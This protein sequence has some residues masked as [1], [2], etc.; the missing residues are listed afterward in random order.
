MCNLINRLSCSEW[1]INFI[2][3]LSG[4]LYPFINGQYRQTPYEVDSSHLMYGCC[5]VVCAHVCMFVCCFVV[6]WYTVYF[7][8]IHIYIYFI[9]SYVCVFMCIVCVFIHIH[10]HTFMI[11]ICVC[12]CYTIMCTCT[13]YPS[14]RP[15]T[16]VTVDKLQ[17]D[18]AGVHVSSIAFCA[19][20]QQHIVVYASPWLLTCF[21]S[22]NKPHFVYQLCQTT[23][24][25]VVQS[26]DVITTLLL[27]T[28]VIY[29]TDMNSLQ[30]LMH[31]ARHC[32]ASHP[33][34]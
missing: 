17:Q 14:I 9:C 29:Y 26:V 27:L 24:L 34:C 11:Y 25:H 6:C 13:P 31:L 10:I 22:N 7:V 18:T 30:W 32:M 8:H 21:G 3:C 12:L 15:Y 20:K 5:F 28:D 1:S 2:G 16:I 19:R 23:I 33:F 4:K